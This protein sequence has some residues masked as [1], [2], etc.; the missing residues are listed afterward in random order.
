MAARPLALLLAG[1]AVAGCRVEVGGQGAAS[2]QGGVA[3]VWV[4]TSIYQEVIDQLTPAIEAEL[5]GVT[6]AWFQGGSE[7]VAQRWEA[8]HEAGRSRACLVATSDP[9]WYVDLHERG[10]LLPYVSP[11]ALRM[12]RS[13]IREDFAPFR[14]GF[15]VL[16]AS[17]DDAPRSFRELTDPRWKDRFS[18]GDPLASGTTFSTLAAWEE[19]YGQDFV[20]ALYGNGWIAA[21]GNSAVMTRMESGE[22]PIGVVLLE[23]LLMKPG[24]ARIIV[25][26]DG[27]VPIPGM[28]AIPRDCAEPEAARR[29]YDWLMGESAQR[30]IVAG[31][32]YSPFPDVAPPVGAPPL[33]ELP[34]FHPDG[35]LLTYMAE[36]S[37]ALKARYQDL[38]R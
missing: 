33:A 35:D 5:P 27:A 34:R 36:N 8:E 23:N 26:E 22:R 3:E 24:V 38:R 19:A 30:A 31:N 11:L 4:Y 7:K 10:Q 2:T 21:G 15:M 37:A 16:A 6:I 29:V 20:R 14:L 9:G 12:D 32:M 13:W 25:P 28:L 17:V 18:S 1:V